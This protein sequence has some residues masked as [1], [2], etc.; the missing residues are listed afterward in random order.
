MRNQYKILAEKYSLI[1]ARDREYIPTNT[2][3]K[4]AVI[5]KENKFILAHKIPRGK[6][7]IV[8][9]VVGDPGS[10]AFERHINQ[11]IKLGFRDLN[12]C[13]FEIYESMFDKLGKYMYF[14]RSK[15][16]LYW[17]NI[18][19]PQS[20]GHFEYDNLT[21]NEINRVTHVDADI[22]SR[23]DASAAQTILNLKASYPN[24]KSMVLVHNFRGH[25]IKSTFNTNALNDSDSVFKKLHELIKIM[26]D[27][28]HGS[29]LKNA[30]EEI[31][32]ENE[33]KAEFINSFKALPNYH[34]L[35]QSYFN[36]GPMI[37]IAA[38]PNQTTNEVRVEGGALTFNVQDTKY[39][40]RTY[41]A[42]KKFTQVL[43]KL[44]VEKVNNYL[45]TKGS[46]IQ[47][48]KN[49]YL[50]AQKILLIIEQIRER[51]LKTSSVS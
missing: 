35:I 25:K 19:N 48:T 38:I 41:S 47:F 11:Y 24:A 15:A 28:A 31:F 32:G 27:A 34:I 42:V 1:E 43:K 49:E 30:F 21:K 26:Y 37:S 40:H 12:I 17:C 16:K 10:G 18:F 39:K 29:H 9:G 44:D 23:I 20:G 5:A 45:E 13:I 36:E 51:N 2:K 6:N 8:V 14:I 22:T 50:Q 4:R 7:D 33:G 46:S 3:E